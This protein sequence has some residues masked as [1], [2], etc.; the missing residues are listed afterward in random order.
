MKTVSF[1]PSAR[2]AFCCSSRRIATSFFFVIAASVFSFEPASPLVTQTEMISLPARPFG[3]RPADGEF[4]IVGMRV[5]R[6]HAR[7]RRGLFQRVVFF[8][9][10][11]GDGR[12][13]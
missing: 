4:L 3:E 11:F 12:V 1:T 7:G 10:A 5:N 13:F 6:Q 9:R 2:F 8:H